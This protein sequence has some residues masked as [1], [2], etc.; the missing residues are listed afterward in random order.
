MQRE[1]EENGDFIETE[2]PDYDEKGNII[3][4]ESPEK[5]N[6]EDDVEEYEPDT[7]NMLVCIVSAICPG[8]SPQDQGPLYR[9]PCKGRLQ[10]AR[11]KGPL[12]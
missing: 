5:A 7:L 9:P 11:Y 6:S 2:L 8:G 1:K 4:A 3:D 12:T 10:R